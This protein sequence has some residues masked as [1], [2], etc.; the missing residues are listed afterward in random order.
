MVW[1]VPSTLERDLS[2]CLVESHHIEKVVGMLGL[3][4]VRLLDVPLLMANKSM[5]GTIA[6]LG[7][8]GATGHGRPFVVRLVLQGDVWLFHLGEI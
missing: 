5:G 2:L 7:P 8:K 3:C 1:C 4:V 6:A